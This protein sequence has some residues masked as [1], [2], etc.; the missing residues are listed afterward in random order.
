MIG[1]WSLPGNVWTTK[2]HSHASTLSVRI[3]SQL[4]VRIALDEQLEGGV[5]LGAVQCISV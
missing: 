4:A 3:F 1:L 5:E 2:L